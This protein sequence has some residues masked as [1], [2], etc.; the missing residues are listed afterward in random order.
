MYLAYNIY[1]LYHII[2]YIRYVYLFMQIF[3]SDV[4]F[5]IHVLTLFKIHP[6]TFEAPWWALWWRLRIREPQRL[7]RAPSR[8]PPG[9]SPGDPSESRSWVIFLGPSWVVHGGSPNEKNM[10]EIMRKHRWFP[11]IFFGGDLSLVV[12]WVVENESVLW[13]RWSVQ[14]FTFSS[15]LRMVDPESG[16]GDPRWFSQ[17]VVM[18]WCTWK[19]WSI[20]PLRLQGIGF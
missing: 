6:A 2:L 4:S 3:T 10:E 7:A 15:F 11:A 18:S 5:C 16:N 9:R 20:Q 14:N 8:D 13:C 17:A 19:S 1:I 12:F